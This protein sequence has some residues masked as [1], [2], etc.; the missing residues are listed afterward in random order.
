[1]PESSLRIL[2]SNSGRAAV[3]Y[4]SGI[5]KYPDI[6]AENSHRPITGS[7]YIG[8]ACATAFDRLPQLRQPGWNPGILQQAGT[9]IEDQQILSPAPRLMP[10]FDEL[11]TTDMPNI[12]GS[13]F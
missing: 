7:P 2:E 11:W 1:M 9:K 4:S 13:R 12:S 6:Q 10:H 8:E 3:R 5:L